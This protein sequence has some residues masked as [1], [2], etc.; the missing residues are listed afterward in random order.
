MPSAI[1]ATKDALYVAESAAQSIAVLDPT[2]G[3]PARR[4]ALPAPPTGLTLNPDGATLY[5]TA[6]ML[7]PIDLATGNATAPVPVGHT[8]MSP[9]ISPDG[10]RLYVCN[11]F[12]NDVSVIDLATRTEIARIPVLREPVA[13][14]LTPDGRSLF[15]A[16][17]LPVGPSDGEFIAAAVS[18]IDTA[19]HTTVG[20]VNLPNGSTGLRGICASPDGKYVYVSHILAHYQMPTTQLERGWM[21]TN[22]VSILSAEQKTLLNTVLLDDA[23]RG[24]AN[25]WAVACSPDGK[26]L[27]VTHAGTHELSVIDRAGLHAKL[28]KTTQ[29][30]Y[31][32]EVSGYA[33]DVSNDFSFLANLR[34]RIKLNGNGP[35]AIAFAGNTAYIAEH[36]S[37][38][39]CA[40]DLAAKDSPPPRG[41]PLANVAPSA[42]RRG[43]MLFN[44][45][46]LCFQHWQ[47]CASCHPDARVDGL[48]WDLLNDGMG[49][50]KNTRSMLLSHQTPPVMGLGIR[51]TAEKAVRSGIRFIQFAE[52]PE[53]DAAA[54]D[55]YLK[56]LKPVP[57]PASSSEA[58]KGKAVFARAGCAPCHPEGLYTDLKQYDVGT[59][60][61]VDAGKPTDTATLIEVWRTAPYLHDGRA[62]TLEE[63]FTRHNPEDRHGT[64]SA[65]TAEELR[66][67][68]AFVESL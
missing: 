63:L 57:G 17:L 56:S 25:P 67:L 35:R 26:Y 65:L 20:V 41:I 19:T 21:N 31:V 61:G 14:T 6:G 12:S 13:A 7:H 55:A 2:S 39:L 37:D 29:G 1:V 58:E 52:R 15:V 44:D 59:T 47:S 10:A 49:N 24:A 9:V 62:A 46:T 38:S 33:V 34:R 45:A 32:S 8:P 50:P 66:Q 22:A 36:F 30:A 27:C 5:V 40:V 42:E 43:E 11:R 54:I 64:T 53:A 51:E 48:N 60:T 18:V 16:N 4:I 28:D 23:M 3:A 68:V